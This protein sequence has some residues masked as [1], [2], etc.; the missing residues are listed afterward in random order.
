M[1]FEAGVCRGGVSEMF[2]VFLIALLMLQGL[3]G[4]EEVCLFL[5]ALAVTAENLQIT[6][7]GRACDLRACMVMRL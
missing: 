1:T 2:A 5:N 7:L 3:E 4:A 6:I